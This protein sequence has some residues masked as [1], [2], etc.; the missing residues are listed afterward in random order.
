MKQKFE[1]RGVFLYYFSSSSKK[2]SML[3]CLLLKTYSLIQI[4]LQQVSPKK[5]QKKYILST[6]KAYIQLVLCIRIHIKF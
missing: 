5:I 1:I 6:K 4:K 3:V 2:V